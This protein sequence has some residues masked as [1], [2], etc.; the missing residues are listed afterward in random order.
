MNRLAIGIQPCANEGVARN[1]RTRETMTANGRYRTIWGRDN[2]TFLHRRGRRLPRARMCFNRI[3]CILPSFVRFWSS[4]AGKQETWYNAGDVRI[5][6]LV[7][8]EPYTETHDGCRGFENWTDSSDVSG[9]LD[10]WTGNGVL[11]S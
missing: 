7:A 6:S 4:I 9:F 5:V 10:P 1:V 8:Y 3:I 11:G 2:K